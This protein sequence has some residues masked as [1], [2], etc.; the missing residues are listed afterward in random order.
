M[1]K[2]VANHLNDIS[3]DHKDWLIT[4]LCK[5][6]RNKTNTAW[7]I[8][9][10]CRSLIKQGHKET[11]L[12]FDVVKADVKIEDFSLDIDTVYLGNN[13]TFDFQIQTN[14]KKTQ[15]HKFQTIAIIN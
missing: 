6:D 12:L 9:H 7:I 8:K 10:G 1:Q 14:S 2:S 4:K 15:N 13:L 3:K 5:W 11:L